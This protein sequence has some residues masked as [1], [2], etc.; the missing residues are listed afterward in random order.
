[1][2]LMFRAKHPLHTRSSCKSLML[3]STVLYKR[4]EG[5]R[6]VVTQYISDNIIIIVR[7]KMSCDT[8]ANYLGTRLPRYYS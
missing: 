7:Y 6:T 3:R 5:D 4:K 1:M 8:G 2:L